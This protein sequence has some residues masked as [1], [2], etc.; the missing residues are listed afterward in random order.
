M[1]E[2]N[3][4]G[5]LFKNDRKQNDRHPDYKGSITV[6]GVEYWLSAWIKSG[7]KG[8]FMSLAVQEKQ[9]RPGQGGDPNPDYRENPDPPPNDDVPF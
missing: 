4:S 7:K 2:Y 6:N 8:K 9:D 1:P 3:N 5:I